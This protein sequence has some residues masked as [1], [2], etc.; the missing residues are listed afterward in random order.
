MARRPDTRA[1]HFTVVE[2]VELRHRLAALSESDLEI[3]YKAAHGACRFVGRRIP[4]KF[5][6]ELVQ[7][8]RELERRAHG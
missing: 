6:Q 4:A 8:W 2:L 5:I 7:A 3:P 1:R